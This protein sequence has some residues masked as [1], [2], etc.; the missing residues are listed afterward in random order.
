MIQAQTLQRQPCLLDDF[1]QSELENAQ[2][3]GN[4]GEDSHSFNRSLQVP[5]L[6][7][8]NIM[9]EENQVRPEMGLQASNIGKDAS[10]LMGKALEIFV[11]ELT[12]RAFEVTSER[13]RVTITEEDLKTVITRDDMYDFYIDFLQPQV[14]D[15]LYV[16]FI[17]CLFYCMYICLY[18]LFSLI[19]Y[20][21]MLKGETQNRRKGRCLHYENA[22]ANEKCQTI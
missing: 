2:N 21:M 18:V 7:L 4:D 8:K 3:I 11:R 19:I 22:F 6:R 1:W 13:C 5:L 17:V 15:V 20:K 9:K 12:S 10:F 16:Y 14:C